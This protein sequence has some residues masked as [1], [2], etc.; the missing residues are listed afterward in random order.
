MRLQRLLLRD[1]RNFAQA[2]LQPHPRINV[3][4]G[5][6]GQGKTTILEAVSYLSTLRSFRGARTEEVVRFGQGHGE[7]RGWIS[8]DPQEGESEGAWQSEFKVV[9]S[10]QQLGLGESRWVKAAFIN[11]KP[12]RSSAA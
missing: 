5:T 11:G 8:P 10:S 2:E 12:F 4:T 7:I 9:F 3:F 6:N 1:F